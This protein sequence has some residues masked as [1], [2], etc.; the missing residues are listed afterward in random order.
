M[1]VLANGKIAAH[2]VCPW[3]IQCPQAQA[4]VCAHNGVKHT[5]EFSCG[6]AR[7]FDI[8]EI[9]TDTEGA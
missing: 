9:P 1:R 4:G 6:M 7:A 3:R 8:A 2:Q 5:I